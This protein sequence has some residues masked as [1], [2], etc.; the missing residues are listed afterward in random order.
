MSKHCSH[1]TLPH[2]G[3]QDSHL[4]NCYCHQDLHQKKF[5]ISLR[6]MVPHFSY[7]LL[8]II[9]ALCNNG[10]VLVLRLSAIHFRGWFIRQVSCYTLLSEFRLPWPP[11]CCP[12][13]PTPFMVSDK[14]GFGTLSKRKEH[15]SSPVLLTKSGPLRISIDFNSSRRKPP[16]HLFK[17]WE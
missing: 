4:N 5:L 2:F 9:T 8:R 12:N 11:S 6:Q 10:L 15:P 3:L 16:M 1:G 14:R 13:E 7:T 17:V